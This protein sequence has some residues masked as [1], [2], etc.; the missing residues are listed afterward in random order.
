MAQFRSKKGPLSGKGLVIWESPK[1]ASGRGQ[2]VASM[3]SP[4]W[5]RMSQAFWDVWP[6]GNRLQAT[7]IVHTE[8]QCI[9]QRPAE[10]SP[11]GARKQLPHLACHL[12]SES[13]P[14]WAL[15]PELPSPGCPASQNTEV[16]FTHVSVPSGR[17]PIP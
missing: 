6:V 17:L 11:L 9:V 7:P 4:F 2:L 3:P 14:A 16:M 15:S 13:M 8:W 12:C 1:V 5:E 10:L